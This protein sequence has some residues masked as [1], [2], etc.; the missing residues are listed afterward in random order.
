MSER[1][2][3]CMRASMGEYMTAL[4]TF[5]RV[6]HRTCMHSQHR[7]TEVTQSHAH[8]HTQHLR[9]TGLI[10]KLHFRHHANVPQPAFE[11]ELHSPAHSRKSVPCYISYERSLW[12]LLF[13]NSH[14]HMP[15]DCHRPSRLRIKSHLHRNTGTDT[16]L[17]V[18]FSS[19]NVHTPTIHT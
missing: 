3:V 12:R 9:H 19:T 13:Q 6:H 17:G 2:C 15:A 5:L 16:S 18:E 10:I 4:Y 7:D 1:V 11:Q 14:L 8:A